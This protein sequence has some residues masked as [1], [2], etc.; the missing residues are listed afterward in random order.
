MQATP[1]IPNTPYDI[2]PVP[3]IGKANQ[4]Q[5]QHQHMFLPPEAE[6][7]SKGETYAGS[8]SSQNQSPQGPGQYDTSQIRHSKMWPFAEESHGT[9]HLPPGQ[10][11]N[12]QH[13]NWGG[14]PIPAEILSSL[15]AYPLQTSYSPNEGS[16]PYLQ[17]SNRPSPLASHIFEH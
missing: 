13:D 3:F 16:R 5:V 15:E 8:G 6:D 17:E 7:F 11:A 1:D 2:S 10:F 4:L 14:R 9:G 12:S